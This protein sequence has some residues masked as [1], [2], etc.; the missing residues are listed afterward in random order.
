MPK[1]RIEFEMGE[2]SDDEKAFTRFQKSGDFVDCLYHIE[3]H[4]KS[5]DKVGK[6]PIMTREEFFEMMENYNINI[7]DYF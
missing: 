5:L 1:V 3:R 4:F 6:D 7:T 2:G